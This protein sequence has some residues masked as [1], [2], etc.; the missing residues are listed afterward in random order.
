[1][2]KILELLSGFKKRLEIL[3]KPK[4]IKKVILPS[5]GT[6]MP[7]VIAGD[8]ASP[9]EGEMWYNST[10]HTWKGRKNGSTVTFTTS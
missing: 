8:P 2:D 3:E 7:P 4:T 5:D 1:M 10:S 6:F 9:T